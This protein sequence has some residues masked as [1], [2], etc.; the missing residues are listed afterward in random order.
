MQ[1]AINATAHGRVV[2]ESH[3]PTPE[4]VLSSLQYDELYPPVFSQ[5]ATYIRF[6]STVEDCCGCPYDMN[7]EDEV[8]LKIMNEKRDP[9]DRCTEDQFEE[10]MNFF[11]EAV[12]IKQPF[13]AVDRPPV[14]SFA[15]TEECM[16]ATVDD[17]V[18]RFAKDVY[19]HWRARRANNGNQSLIEKLKVSIILHYSQTTADLPSV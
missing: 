12:R 4:T 10:V 16:D 17:F 7:S 11:E 15:E 1:V 6:S 3:I 13:A 14:L 9:A 18:K 2:N 5:P 8:F 19:D